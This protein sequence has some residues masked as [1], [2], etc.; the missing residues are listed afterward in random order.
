GFSG[1]AL[2]AL[3]LAAA[4]ASGC[5]SADNAIRLAPDATS[6]SLVFTVITTRTGGPPASAYGL[7]VLRCGD[8]SV[9]WMLSADGTRHMPTRITYGRPLPGYVVKTGP[10]TLRPGCYRVILSEAAPLL[11]DVLPG[12]AV[13]DRAKP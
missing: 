10:D 6:D 8:D 5:A 9:F 13:H 2:A 12:G 11:I 4:C 7:S 3:M 1:V